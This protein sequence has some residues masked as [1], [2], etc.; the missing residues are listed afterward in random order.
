MPNSRE[1]AEKCEATHGENTQ[2]STNDFKVIMD[3]K[4]EEFETSWH[5][6]VPQGPVRK[7]YFYC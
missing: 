3:K 1:N 6:K 2:D 7:G 4:F 5:F